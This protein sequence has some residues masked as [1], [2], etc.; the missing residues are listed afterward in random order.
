MPVMERIA[1]ANLRLD[2]RYRAAMRSGQVPVEDGDP[3]TAAIREQMSS[4]RE[5]EKQQSKSNEPVLHGELLPPIHGYGSP[6]E[7]FADGDELKRRKAEFEK[8]KEEPGMEQVLRAR[9]YLNALSWERGEPAPTDKELAEYLSW[10]ETNRIPVAKAGGQAAAHRLHRGDDPNERAPKR[11][12]ADLI[13]GGGLA[14]IGKIADSLETLLDGRSAQQIEKDE[15]I[16]AE[17][18]NIE[19]ITEQQQRQQE[20]E[21]EKWR[22]I[23]LQ[24]YLEQRDRERHIDRGR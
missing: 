5:P 12:A 4:A 10:A 17:K 20:A 1:Q 14:A 15:T 13:A 21:A 22:Q 18:R 8:L 9:D 3:I 7:P 11:D 2:A 19:Q 24:R 23:E 16:V 6:A